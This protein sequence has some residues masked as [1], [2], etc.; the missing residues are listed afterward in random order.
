MRRS[1]VQCEIVEFRPLCPESC[2]WVLSIQNLVILCC[3]KRWNFF[4]GHSVFSSWDSEFVASLFVEPSEN[5]KLLFEPPSPIREFWWCI[6]W[7]SCE[8]YS[9]FQFK[10]SPKQK[11]GLNLI[12]GH[13]STR[14]AKVPLSLDVSLCLPLGGLQTQRNNF[15]FSNQVRKF[16]CLGKKEHISFANMALKNSSRFRVLSMSHCHWTRYIQSWPKKMKWQ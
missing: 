2:Q 1:D 8:N 5:F 6:L 12:N 9:S 10:V 13:I 14:T 16:V 4:A 15:V 3:R 7:W 11:L